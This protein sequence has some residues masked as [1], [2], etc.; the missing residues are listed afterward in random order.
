MLTHHCHALECV[1]PTDPVE[2][3]CSRHWS[4]VPPALAAAVI[5]LY[6]PG[7]E[8]DKQPTGEYVIAAFRAIY[9]V[10]VTEGTATTAEADH[11]IDVISRRAGK[12]VRVLRRFAEPTT[13]TAH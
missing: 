11:M 12:L 7:Q 8:I 10:A 1:V 5:D 3:M 13:A 2:L 9:A 4:M 6:R